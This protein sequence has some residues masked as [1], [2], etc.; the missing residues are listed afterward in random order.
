MVIGQ[1]PGFSVRAATT[2]RTT[3][4][5]SSSGWR[6]APSAPVMLTTTG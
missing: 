1:P 3:A 4:S 5:I 6:T 2:S